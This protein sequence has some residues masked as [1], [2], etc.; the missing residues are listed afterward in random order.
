MIDNLSLLLG[1]DFETVEAVGDI[2]S[3]YIQYLYC[4]EMVLV[5]VSRYSSSSLVFS[6]PFIGLFWDTISIS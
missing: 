4:D 3:Q 6:S 2:S 5:V 1:S